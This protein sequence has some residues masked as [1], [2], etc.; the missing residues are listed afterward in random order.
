MFTKYQDPWWWNLFIIL[1]PKSGKAQQS[2]KTI[3]QMAEETTKSIV[4]QQKFLI[5]LP[6]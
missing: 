4:A 1:V 5:S 6:S 2:T 3:D